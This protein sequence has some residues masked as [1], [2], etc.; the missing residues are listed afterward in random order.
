M[1]VLFFRASFCRLKRLLLSTLFSP[2]PRRLSPGMPDWQKA[3]KDQPA[4]RKKIWWVTLVSRWNVDS[5]QPKAT[6]YLGWPVFG[7]VSQEHIFLLVIV[8]PRPLYKCVGSRVALVQLQQGGKL[9]R[10]RNWAV[11]PTTCCSCFDLHS[12]VHPLRG[13]SGCRFLC[14]SPLASCSCKRFR[15]SAVLNCSFGTKKRKRETYVNPAARVKLGE[16]GL[17]KTC[18][19]RAREVAHKTRCLEKLI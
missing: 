7:A 2:I 16:F 17:L 15:V 10:L 1:P 19:H 12:L 9:T 8:G 18:T 11:K 14:P 4:K 13:R 3:K 5:E 6:S